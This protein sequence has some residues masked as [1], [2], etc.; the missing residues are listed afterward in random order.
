MRIVT[1]KTAAS[2]DE[3]AGRFY[4][5]EGPKGS[6][7]AKQ[8]EAALRQ[9]NPHL[10]DLNTIPEG[11]VILVP[12]KEGLKPKA[13]PEPSF[14]LG[15]GFAQL[16][17]TLDTVGKNLLA[18]QEKDIEDAKATLTRAKSKDF[19]RLIDTEELKATVADTVKN[20]Q[21]RIK[22]AEKLQGD[23]AKTMKRAGT[24]LNKLRDRFGGTDTPPKAAT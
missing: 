16:T 4:M 6:T 13:D 8:A 17:D 10:G 9:A 23:I 14:A 11:A 18:A 7:A 2:L 12:D 19:A 3:I 20:A 24:D 1:I 15:G 22:A 21:A 5:I